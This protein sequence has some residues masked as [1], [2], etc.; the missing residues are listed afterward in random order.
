MYLWPKRLRFVGPS[1][2]QSVLAF[3][4][5]IRQYTGASLLRRRRSI[6]EEHY[7]RRDV[8][9]PLNRRGTRKDR[10]PAG[11]EAVQTLQI[12]ASQDPV[13]RLLKP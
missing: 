7:W 5:S 9:R 1:A 4:Q 6:E 10:L 13:R 3:R 2:K 12:P 8:R 11:R